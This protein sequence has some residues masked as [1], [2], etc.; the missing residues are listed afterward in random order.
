VV[1]K[2]AVPYVRDNIKVIVNWQTL[3]AGT[4]SK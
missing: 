3:I 1:L 4:T 2:S